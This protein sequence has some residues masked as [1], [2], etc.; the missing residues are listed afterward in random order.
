MQLSGKIAS[1]DGTAVQ[2]KDGIS[3]GESIQTE[4][5]GDE[6]IPVSGL[7]I[8]QTQQMET[9]IVRCFKSSMPRSRK[10]NI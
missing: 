1:T 2:F 6:R 9:I 10:K 3:G 5:D 4:P 7:Q 8:T